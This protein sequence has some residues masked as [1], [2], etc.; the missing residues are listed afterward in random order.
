MMMMVCPSESPEP[1]AN[2][3]PKR[4]KPNGGGYPLS[5]VP[6]ER[7][8]RWERAQGGLPKGEKGCVGLA[9]RTGKRNAINTGKRERQSF[10]SNT[11]PAFSRG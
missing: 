4:Q 8:D 3:L 1:R 5:S 2:P 7:I 9:R 6:S 11:R 10:L